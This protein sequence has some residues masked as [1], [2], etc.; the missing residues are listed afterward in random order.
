MPAEEEPQ[1]IRSR[2]GGRRRAV[3]LSV[4]LVMV[5]RPRSASVVLIRSR[6]PRPLKQLLTATGPARGVVPIHRG[7]RA[8]GRAA[9]ACGAA[10]FGGAVRGWSVLPPACP[11]A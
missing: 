11:P 9:R 10:S 8:R 4:I 2:V 7:R 6:T 1:L 5:A 3:E